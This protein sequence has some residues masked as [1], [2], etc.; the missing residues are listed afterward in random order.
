MTEERENFETTACESASIGNVRLT[1]NAVIQSNACVGR[2]HFM[3][4]FLKNISSVQLQYKSFPIWIVLA[5]ISLI[6]A[7]LTYNNH[8]GAFG[9]SLILM[10]I[11]L[12]LFFVTCKYIL[13]ITARG[14][15]K[16]VEIIDNCPNVQEFVDKLIATQEKTL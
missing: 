16:M 2:K 9:I 14:G 13:I 12:V 6:A 5:V 3:Q 7:L 11:F 15:E 10:I 4:I 1:N 8:D